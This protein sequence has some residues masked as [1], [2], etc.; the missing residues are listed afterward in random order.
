MP[1]YIL[2]VDSAAYDWNP[3]AVSDAFLGTSH[4]LDAWGEHFINWGGSWV[5]RVPDQPT[6]S[7][8]GAG[9]TGHGRGRDTRKGG[10]R[11]EY[12]NVIDDAH[13]LP[14]YQQR[15]REQQEAKTPRRSREPEEAVDENDPDIVRM[16]QY[17]QSLKR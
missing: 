7:A 3:S 2:N 13:L 9:Q 17:L 12:L 15:Q 11:Y 4:D 5:Y 16:R 1:N 6:T 8:G 10:R 14:L